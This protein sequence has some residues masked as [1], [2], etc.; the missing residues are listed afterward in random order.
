M[1]KAPFVLLAAVTLASVLIGGFP[2]SRIAGAESL[3][4]PVAFALCTAEGPQAVEKCEAIGDPPAYQVPQRRRLVIEQVSGDC[5][6]DGEPGLPLKMTIVAQ[7]GGVVVEHG[8][9]GVPQAPLPG[10][11]I[12]LTRTRI[13]ADPKSSVTIGLTGI[14]A[15]SGRF[16]RVAFSG[17]LFK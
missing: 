11:Q 17:L 3:G 10:G 6:G 16:C 7:T 4:D 5:G 1:S 14:P 2:S 13:Y 12:P 15:F 8:I 9:I